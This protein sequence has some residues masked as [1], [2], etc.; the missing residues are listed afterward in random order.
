MSPRILVILAH[1]NLAQSQINRAMAE[2]VADL[3][4][5]T[6]HKLYETYPDGRIDA[7][8]EQAL[9][10][11]HDIVVFQ[12]PLYWYSAPALLREWQDK[13]LAYGFAYGP[14]GDAVVGKR[15]FSAIST[16][17]SEGS[18]QAGG[19]NNFAVGEFLRPAQQLASFTR[20]VHLPAFVFHDALHTTPAAI[21]AHAQS[22]REHLQALAQPEAKAA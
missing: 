17:G 10:Q 11:A 5:V 9:L 14:G 1:P 13:V 12:H 3:P 22:W 20:M 8:R 19:S 6:V 2:A 21:A 4:Q 18:Y 16:G 15:L 7:A